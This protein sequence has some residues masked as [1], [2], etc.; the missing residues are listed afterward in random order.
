MCHKYHMHGQDLTLAEVID[1]I[2]NRPHTK[3]P[4]VYSQ[5]EIVSA[6][7]VLERLATRIKAPVRVI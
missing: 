3:P 1:R 4:V 2:H 7:K 5:Q 6:S